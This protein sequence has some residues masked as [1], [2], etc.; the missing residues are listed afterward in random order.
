[1][2]LFITSI[3]V[4]LAA[5]MVTYIFEF[6]WPRFKRPTT[7]DSQPPEK[8]KETIDPRS[9]IT[10]DFNTEL[11]YELDK[12]KEVITN[13]PLDWKYQYIP[14]NSG[15]FLLQKFDNGVVI[16][17]FIFTF[18]HPFFA[19]GRQYFMHG[20]TLIDGWKCYTHPWDFLGFTRPTVVEKIKTAISPAVATGY[21]EI[22]FPKPI[23]TATRT[24]SNMD[25]CIFV[26]NL[27]YSTTSDGLLPGGR[28]AYY[29]GQALI[30]QQYKDNLSLIV[31]D[32]VFGLFDNIVFD[33]KNKEASSQV[34]TS[35]KMQQITLKYTGNICDLIRWG[36]NC[37][38]SKN[39][40]IVHDAF[41]AGTDIDALFTGDEARTLIEYTSK[42]LLRQALQSIYSTLEF[43]P[44]NGKV[45]YSI[46]YTE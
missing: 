5:W 44:L 19:A 35:D 29:N 27:A 28:E 23:T 14:G 20:D 36:F 1:M 8:I 30:Y 15:C 13:M 4:V 39:E 11:Y 26:I 22:A 16:C 33:I 9:I 38:L 45:G 24:L 17:R 32:H 40:I 6:G 12:I 18:S 37:I 21:E 2:G 3:V 25:V 7:K 34:I 46:T 41:L 43:E 42:K 31:Q 10:G